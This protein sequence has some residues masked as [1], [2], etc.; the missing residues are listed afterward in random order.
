MTPPGVH[1]APFSVTSVRA[2]I[3]GRTVTSVRAAISGRTVTSVRAAISGRAT[4]RGI[5]LPVSL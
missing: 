2:A 1:R 4:P 5:L 3:S